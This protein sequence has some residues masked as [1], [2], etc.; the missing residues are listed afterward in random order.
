MNGVDRRQFL[1]ALGWSALGLTVASGCSLIP[2]LPSRME[3]EPEQEGVSWVQVR[4]DG[5][6]VFASP[7]QEMGQG[8]AISFMAIVA[9][10]L[11]VPLERVELILPD[12]RLLGTPVPSTVGSESIE[13]Q[14]EVV[15]GMAASLREV[16][17]RRAAS[18]FGARRGA[19]T[20]SNGTISGPRGASVTYGELAL[21][22]E[23]YEPIQGVE[24]R[25]FRPLADRRHVGKGAPIEEL[26]G[27]V[28][29]IGGFVDD[30]RLDGMLHGAVLRGPTVGAQPVEADFSLAQKKPGWVAGVFTDG[31]VG[32]V[33]QHRHQLDAIAAATRVEWEPAKPSTRVR[34]R[35]R[36]TST[37]TS[38][39][40]RWSMKSSTGMSMRRARGT[41][42]CG[43]TFPSPHTRR[44][45]RVAQSP[46]HSETTDGVSTPRPRMHTWSSGVSPSYWV[47]IPTTSTW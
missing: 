33:A 3:P 13:L 28:K 46:S 41:S 36:G 39:K 11:D 1:K 21:D 43:S 5:R 16:L 26:A 20:L 38:M 10:E 25:S 2:P 37:V 23:V 47:S 24:L 45:S 40:T 32:V 7:K 30:V 9:E 4:P 6:I 19:L 14:M 31:I 27:L 8:V 44:S 15:A 29:G 35:G 34:W 17:M 18:R 22:T 12:T 42:I